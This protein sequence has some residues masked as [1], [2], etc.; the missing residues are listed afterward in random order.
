M[1]KIIIHDEGYEHLPT[2]YADTIIEARK[3]RKTAKKCGHKKV[4]IYD[5]GWKKI[6]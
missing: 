5:G 6:S 4:N 2:A 1:Y 3:I